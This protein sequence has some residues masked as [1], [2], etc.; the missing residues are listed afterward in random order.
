MTLLCA[1]LSVSLSSMA[2]WLQVMLI[3]SCLVIVLFVV[4]LPLRAA[5]SPGLMPALFL[6][7]LVVMGFTMVLQTE[8]PVPE[9]PPAMRRLFPDSK[10]EV[11]MRVSSIQ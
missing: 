5:S 10:T 9:L 2:L 4:T 3:I 11:R 7:W 1:F 6:A 8:L